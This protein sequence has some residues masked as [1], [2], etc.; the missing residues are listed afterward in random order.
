MLSI[1]TEDTDLMNNF[2]PLY[3]T[4]NLIENEKKYKILDDIEHVEFKK[5]NII[6]SINLCS[7]M[8]LRINSL[9]I[10]NEI[11]EYL[12]DIYISE[13]NNIIYKKNNYINRVINTNDKTVLHL[14]FNKKNISDIIG[15]S[16]IL[17]YTIICKKSKSKIC[18]LEEY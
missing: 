18:L 13:N 16:V 4:S 7:N 3:Y 9:K 2:N 10:P 14:V 5:N 17:N 6:L 15:C 8:T 12:N 11:N 1:I